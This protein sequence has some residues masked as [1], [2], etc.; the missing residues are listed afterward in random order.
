MADSKIVQYVQKFAWEKQSSETQRL[1][2]RAIIDLLGCSLAG[3]CHTTVP[4][5]FKT[6]EGIDGKGCNYVWGTKDSC[7]VKG[8]VFMN[9]YTGAL[10]D[11]DDGH[12]KAQGHPGAVL[13]P[14]AITV[15]AQLGSSG[16]DVLEA[17]CVGYDVAI[18]EA[19][20]IREAGGPRKGSSGWC[21]PGAAATVGK[22]LK[23]TDEQMAN[24]I[25]LSEYFTP[26][27]GQDRSV[28]FPS[29]MKEGIPWGAYTG[30]FCAQ[31]AK[32]GFTAHRP[33]L[34]DAEELCKDLYERVEV[35]YAYYKKWAACR[36]AHP[37]LS[38]MDMIKK[39][40]PYK[41]SDVKHVELRSFEKG[42]LLKNRTPKSTLE[43]VYSIP[44]SLAYWLK[45]GKIEPDDVKNE[46]S[47]VS[48]PEILD[49]AQRID[50]V[51]AEEYTAKFPLQCIQDVKLTFQDGTTAEK[52]FLESPGDP[53]ERAFTDQEIADKFKLLAEPVVGAKWKDILDCVNTLEQVDDVSKLTK[54]LATF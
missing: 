38:G 37:A 20:R 11:M 16:K 27:A 49:M 23:L 51:H 48:D 50:M 3:S 35:D 9:A 21:A 43:A 15:G 10:F 14:A 6:I 42:L 19:V 25:G 1:A 31:L 17:V 7:D 4:G 36:W 2:K 8:A 40:K 44:F 30:N 54:L 5:V 28:Q 24:A 33:H 32:G 45:H 52:K 26:Q 34:A 39:E 47:M 22:L 53:G 29:M 18:R 46:A 13:V 12:R 41:I